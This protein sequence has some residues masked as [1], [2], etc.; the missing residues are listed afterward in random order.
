MKYIFLSALFI[1]SAFACPELAGTF[2]RCE[3]SRMN[4]EIRQNDTTF[5]VTTSMN[6]GYE[7]YRADG[8]PDIVS[9]IEPN[10]GV[11]IDIT[12]TSDCSLDSLKAF[13]TYAFDGE[14]L[15]SHEA[16]FR[17][18]GKKLILTNVFKTTKDEVKEEFVCLP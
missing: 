1:S 3:N 12:T 8:R 9:F 6:K 13:R 11:K 7:V 4:V 17:K 15:G 14:V 5:H 10:T 18:E 2:R 16:T